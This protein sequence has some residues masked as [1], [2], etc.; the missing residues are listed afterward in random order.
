MVASTPMVLVVDI[1]DAQREAIGVHLEDVDIHPVSGAPLTDPLLIDGESRLVFTSPAAGSQ[2]TR[3]AS[4]LGG[5]ELSFPAIEAIAPADVASLEVVEYEAEDFPA[6]AAY[7]LDVDGAVVFGVPVE[8]EVPEPYL[9]ENLMDDQG[10]GP[11]ASPLWIS[12]GCFEPDVTPREHQVDVTLRFGAHEVVRTMA[13]TQDASDGS[14]WAADDNC[15]S[16]VRVEGGCFCSSDDRGPG[17]AA[18][19]ALLVLLAVRRRPSVA[20]A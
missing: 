2:P 7:G 3:L 10:S 1:Y 9:V 12:D 6:L 16:V 11:M 17:G 4:T 15:S 5:R 19:L 13:W 18:A 20:R 8:V 14:S